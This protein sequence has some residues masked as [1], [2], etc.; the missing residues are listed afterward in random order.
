MRAY[1]AK[2]IKQNGEARDILFIKI[3]DLPQSFIET[4]LKGKSKPK[5]SDPDSELVWDLEKQ[6]FRTL[7]HKTIIGE[8]VELDTDKDLI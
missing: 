1:K 8:I 4:K 7:N 5:V 3:K 2:Y 6:G